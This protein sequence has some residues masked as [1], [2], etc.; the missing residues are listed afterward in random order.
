M[1]TT[2]RS[3]PIEAEEHRQNVLTDISAARSF[4]Q[5]AKTAVLDSHRTLASLALAEA[6][7]QVNDAATQL[8]Y[9][10]QV[11]PEARR[12]PSVAL[13]VRREAVRY[14][15]HAHASLTSARQAV[16]QLSKEHSLLALTDAEGML[17]HVETS[18]VRIAA[19]QSSG[20]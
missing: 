18:L 12:W 3:W 20:A 9:A 17:A 11:T 4:I 6:L 10:E 7:V 5:R 14:I 2:P 19:P 8:A 1:P 13:T 16:E 15:N